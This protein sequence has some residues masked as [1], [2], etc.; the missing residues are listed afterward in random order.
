MRFIDH[1][2]ACAFAGNKRLVLAAVPGIIQ[3]PVD[4]DL[5]IGDSSEN[6]FPHR[7]LAI[8]VVL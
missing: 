8:L 1:A 3:L 2:V 7:S 4:A 5:P 6:C